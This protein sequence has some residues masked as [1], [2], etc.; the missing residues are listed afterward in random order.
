MH[1]EGFSASTISSN[2][3][4][5]ER[6]IVLSASEHVLFLHTLSPRFFIF[7]RIS[8]F[9]P[10]RLLI[11]FLS[12]HRMSTISSRFINYR[13]YILFS[14]TKGT[15]FFENVSQYSQFAR[16]CSGAIFSWVGRGISM[17]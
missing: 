2:A 14:E 16:G 6:G 9:S 15:A 1:L 11:F 4:G 7:P 13:S 17:I 5:R 10:I 8:L 12:H 3:S